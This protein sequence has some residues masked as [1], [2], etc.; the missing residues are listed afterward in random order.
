VAQHLDSDLDNIVL[1]ALRTEPQ[2]RY[3]SVQQFAEDLDRFLQQLPVR[4]RGG[5]LPYRGLKLLKRNR[6]P[7]V[8]AALSAVLVLAL[9]AA[10]EQA[11]RPF[12]ARN[13]PLPS[14]PSL[15]CRLR[16][17]PAI[18]SRSTLPME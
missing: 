17:F 1:M 14:D 10:L 7:A 3:A 9:V 2:Q 8:A 13:P 6:L 18:A 5:S 16:A 11:N 12:E 15:C 4:A